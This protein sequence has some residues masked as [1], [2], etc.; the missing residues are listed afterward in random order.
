MTD[1]PKPSYGAGGETDPAVWEMRLH[2]SADPGR[3]ARVAV[4]VDGWPAQQFALLLRDW[5]SA[6]DTARREYADLKADAATEAAQKSDPA[7]AAATY[8]ALKAPWFD[9]AHHARGS[10]PRAPAG[11]P[12]ESGS[13]AETRPGIFRTLRP[14]K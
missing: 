4:R 1:E 9:R 5:L 12:R 2:G 8:A 14:L 10:G 6:V 11:R 7:E 13:R 3:P